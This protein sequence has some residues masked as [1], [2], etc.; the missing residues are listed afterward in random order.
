MRELLHAE[1]APGNVVYVYIHVH[2]C[3]C[4]CTCICTCMC[5]TVC[6][7]SDDS[8]IATGSAKMVKVWNRYVHVH[9]HVY[10]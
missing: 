8:Y 1:G 6:F 3:T 2:V 5:R 4:V 10:T 7:S 9:V